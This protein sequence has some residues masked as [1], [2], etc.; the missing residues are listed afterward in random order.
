MSERSV[1][2]SPERMQAFVGS[3]D[4]ETPIVMVNL[5]RYRDEA[6]YAGAAG[7]GAGF[8]ASPCTGREAY[9][10]YGAVAVEC[11]AE[12]GGRVQWAGRVAAGVIAPEGEE[13]D[14]VVL[15]RYP[16]RAAFLRMLASERYRAVA[17]HRTAALLDSRLIATEGGGPLSPGDR[18]RAAVAGD[19][20]A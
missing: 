16:S 17:P 11:V 12:A 19:N 1:E 8:D 7:T 14:D 13:W 20:G 2:P 9:A 15:V 6:D 3:A 18:E 10:R 5:L 4:D